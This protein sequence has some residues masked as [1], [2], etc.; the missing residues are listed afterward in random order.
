MT[1]ERVGKNLKQ[2]QEKKPLEE[3][4]VLYPCYLDEKPPSPNMILIFF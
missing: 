1:Q 2:K 3:E 4:N